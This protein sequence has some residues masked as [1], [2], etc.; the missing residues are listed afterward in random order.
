MA[1]EQDRCRDRSAPSAGGARSG[2]R[3]IAR[4]SAAT[5]PVPFKVAFRHASATRRRAENLIVVAEDAD[6]RFGYGEGC[7]RGYVTGESVADCRRFVCEHGARLAAEVADVRELRAWVAAN[8]DLIDRHPAAFCA[9][10]TALLDL[11]GKAQ[12]AS[13]ESL[14]GVG[15]IGGPYRYSAVLGDAPVPVFRWQLR[16]YRRLGLRDFK[17]KLSP[18]SRRNRARLRL[19][20]G[21]N[22]RVRLDANNLWT[23]PDA[24]IDH[25]CALPA[26]P[27][28]AFAI[29]EP[30]QPGDVEG[31]REVA[32]AL[33]LGIILDESASRVEHLSGLSPLAPPGRWL[34]NLRVSKMGGLIRSLAFVVAARRRGV[35]LIVGCQV[36][37]TSILARAALAVME[38]VGPGLVAAEGAFG[39]YLL[40]RDIASPCLMFGQDGELR[41]PPALANAG[42]LGL[43]VDA[44]ALRRFGGAS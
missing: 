9:V 22:W 28:R 38:A 11:F 41:A 18:A 43:W 31:C 14:L 27:K 42:G 6:G 1:S 33:G 44:A 5:F 32:A 34:V 25:L 17:V 15:P 39:T 30:L 16:R 8:A 24:C 21:A 37:E 19:L 7:P 36:G 29:E 26:L 12:G 3:R 4:L 10:E 35:G 2:R 23:H 13:L 20:D 40:R